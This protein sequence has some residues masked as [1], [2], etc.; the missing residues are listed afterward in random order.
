MP[1]A[2]TV[3]YER[4][5]SETDVRVCATCYMLD[6]GCW[7]LDAARWQEEDGSARVPYETG[8][9]R[10]SAAMDSVYAAERPVRFARGTCVLYLLDTWHR[11]TP[12][13]LVRISLTCPG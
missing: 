6:A 12:V 8:W 4:H 5:R 7:M 11:G 13:A 3:Q 1:R 2:H 9:R 10:D